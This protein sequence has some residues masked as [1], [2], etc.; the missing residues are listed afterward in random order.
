[1]PSPKKPSAVVAAEVNPRAKASNYPEP[2]ATQ[3]AGRTKRQLGEVFGLTNF[4]VNLTQMAPGAIS[5]LRHWHSQ[6]DEFIYVLEGCVTLITDG[7]ETLLSAGMCAGFKAGEGD[8]HQL[9]NR[10]ELPALYLE[11]GDRTQG[12]QVFYP[13][14]DLEA[15][16]ENSQWRFRHKNGEAY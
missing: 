14:D 3:V 13:D 15:Y 9:V 10:S 2:F 5:A 6:Q 7:G 8:G 12:D 1:M 4:G 11:V 16:T